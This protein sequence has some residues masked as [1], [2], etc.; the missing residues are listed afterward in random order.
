MACL[1]HLP[2]PLVLARHDQRRKGKGLQ[3]I[4]YN[5]VFTA[6]PKAAAA[7]PNLRRGLTRP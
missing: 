3:E 1:V 6:N 4:L 7:H 2:N 5:V